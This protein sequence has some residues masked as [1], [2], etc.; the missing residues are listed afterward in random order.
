MRD[1]FPARMPGAWRAV[2][3]VVVV[4]FALSLGAPAAT[5][6][7][8]GCGTTR[9][10]YSERGTRQY[11]EMSAIRASRVS[12]SRARTIALDWGAHSRLSYLPAATGAGFLCGYTRAG[13]DVGNVK[14]AKGRAVVTFA[15][16]DSSPYH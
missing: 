2:A 9:A 13:S 8:I 5:G 7:T 10:H 15:A 4:W 1:I 14:C 6:R 3:T 12:C 11:V 16:Y